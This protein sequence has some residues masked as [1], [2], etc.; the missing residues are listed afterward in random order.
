MSFTRFTEVLLLGWWMCA[1]H[2]V[3]LSWFC[4]LQGSEE[5][6][7]DAGIMAGGT[8]MLVVLPFL[9]DEPNNLCK[10]AKVVTFFYIACVGIFIVSQT[11]RVS[12]EKDIYEDAELMSYLKLWRADLDEFMTS[13]VSLAVN[14]CTMALILAAQAFNLARMQARLLILV[15]EARL[16]ET[17]DRLV[18]FDGK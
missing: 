15:L 11:M 12:G 9:V 4:T 14:I 8:M 7:F 18:A 2:F 3:A 16:A 10:V 13:L 6:S 5:E 1:L 17:A